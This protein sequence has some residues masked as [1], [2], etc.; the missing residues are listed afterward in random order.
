MM[1]TLA[2]APTA[3]KHFGC[4]CHQAVEG[5]FPCGVAVT[6]SILLGSRLSFARSVCCLLPRA[7]R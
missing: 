4:G 6:M 5:R 1:R 3:T 2:N 7:G